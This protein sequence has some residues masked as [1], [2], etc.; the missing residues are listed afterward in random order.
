MQLSIS[1]LLAALAAILYCLFTSSDPVTA[2]TPYQEQ[3]AEA[4]SLLEA[5]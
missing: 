1:I 4:L 2:F 3:R 5:N